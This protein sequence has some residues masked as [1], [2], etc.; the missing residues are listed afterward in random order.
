MGSSWSW[1]KNLVFLKTWC[2]WNIFTEHQVSSCILIPH[3]TQGEKWDILP[4]LVFSSIR[5]PHLRGIFF[6]CP[7]PVSNPIANL[8]S[9]D[10]MQA[11]GL[12][13]C[14]A[15]NGLA[16]QDGLADDLYII[17]QRTV[18]RRL[19]SSLLSSSLLIPRKCF[20]NHCP[21]KMVQQVF[22]TLNT[23]L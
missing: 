12:S 7:S 16:M 17:P 15:V 8:P 19:C 6:P 21:T 2:S 5:N 18:S 4:H 20:Y 14:Q 1:V 11:C 3:Q 9:C 22:T 23:C 13:M 10:E